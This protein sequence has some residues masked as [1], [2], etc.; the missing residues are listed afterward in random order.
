[1]KPL[2]RENIRMP[3]NTHQTTLVAILLAQRFD[4]TP[5]VAAL[6]SEFGMS[7]ATAYRWRAAWIEAQARI[8]ARKQ[9]APTEQAGTK[10]SDDRRAA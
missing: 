6:R 10:A 5:S 7:R 3:P 8:G 4:S 2:Y 1:M 9:Q